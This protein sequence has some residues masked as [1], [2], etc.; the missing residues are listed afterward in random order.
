MLTVLPLFHVYGMS[1][2]LNLG[3]RFGAA[4][5]RPAAV[6]RRT[7]FDTFEPPDYPMR[8]EIRSL[9]LA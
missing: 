4:L 3:I 8:S 7:L 2:A 1:S 5:S 6:P 9:Y